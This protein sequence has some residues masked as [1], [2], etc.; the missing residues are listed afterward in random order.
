MKS[1]FM[2]ALA[3]LLVLSPLA[4]ARAE[5]GGG[6]AAGTK[7]DAV[8]GFYLQGGFAVI[9]TNFGGSEPSLG[10]DVAA[11]YRFLPWLGTDVDVY[12]GARD[13]GNGVKPR[14]FGVTFNGKLYPIGLM[15]P[16]TLSS[17]Q[18]YVVVGV[19]G[20]NYRVK[21]GSGTGT[22][23]FRA[24]A[25][26]DWMITNHFGLY[27]DVSLNVTPGFKS[28]GDGGATGVYALGGKFVF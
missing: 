27:T 10:V 1:I 11:G 26:L 2:T 13:L 3:A 22:F 17:L 4:N 14:Q 28:G 19:G 9:K 15:S 7:Y 18:P 20:G 6:K 12:F 5:G 25:G 8:K 16:K 23:I 21:N 24:G